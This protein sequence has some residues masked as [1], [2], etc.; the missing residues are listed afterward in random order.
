MDS[1]DLNNTYWD[2]LKGYVTELRVDARWLLRQIDTDKPLG[3][4]R[5]V[6]H[7]DLSPGYLRAFFTY[8][9]SIRKKSKEEKLQTIEDY[10]MEVTELEVYSIGEDIKTESKTYE[11]PYKELEEMFGVEII[12]RK[13]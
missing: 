3:S 10:Q 5:I 4:L 8:V 11:A 1:V 6:S 12:E 9:I 2:K 13:K 7:P